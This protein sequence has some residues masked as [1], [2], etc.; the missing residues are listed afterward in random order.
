VKSTASRRF[1]SLFHALPGE[2]Q[3]L[4]IKNYRLWLRDPNREVRLASPFASATTIALWE[5]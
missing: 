3:K 1:W 2:V 4:A 5:I